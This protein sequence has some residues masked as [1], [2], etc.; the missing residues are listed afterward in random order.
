MKLQTYLEGIRKC[1]DEIMQIAGPPHQ[2]R[3]LTQDWGISD[4]WVANFSSEGLGKSRIFDLI[5]GK[6]RF[7]QS[8]RLATSTGFKDSDTGISF[9]VFPELVNRKGAL[10]PLHE[11]PIINNYNAG[12]I[13]ESRIGEDPQ[14]PARDTIAALLDLLC[15]QNNMPMITTNSI[16]WRYHSVIKTPEALSGIVI[17]PDEVEE[18]FM[19]RIREGKQ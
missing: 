13:V 19:R 4:N 8:Y 1:P 9:A 12:F 7:A 6:K 15:L 10:Y 3:K 11:H 17:F 2:I 18:E 14:S 5:R 16:G